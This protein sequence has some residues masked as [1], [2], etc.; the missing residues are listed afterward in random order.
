MVYL[1]I[2]YNTTVYIE[3]SKYRY[4]NTYFHKWVEIVLQLV[5]ENIYR[6][7]HFEK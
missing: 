5:S 4:Y 6:T 1:S 7:M 2:S 3:I